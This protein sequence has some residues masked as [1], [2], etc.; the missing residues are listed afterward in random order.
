MML[1]IQD[2]VIEVSPKL[3]DM[4][5]DAFATA[6]LCFYKAD[7]LGDYKLEK[8]VPYH[9]IADQLYNQLRK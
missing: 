3:A 7:Y 4:L 9:K 5:H 2:E 6:S 8:A 1:K